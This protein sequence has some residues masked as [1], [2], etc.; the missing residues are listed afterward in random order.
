MEALH[1]AGDDAA[2]NPSLSPERKQ[3]KVRI[4]LEQASAHRSVESEGVNVPSKVAG[5]MLSR[6]HVH[7]PYFA[8]VSEGRFCPSSIFC[9]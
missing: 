9:A 2:S 6:P 7:S 5:G 1:Q 3:G 8:W 4:F